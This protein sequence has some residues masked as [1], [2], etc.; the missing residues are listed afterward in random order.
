MLG[1]GLLRDGTSTEKESRQRCSVD[2]EAGAAFLCKNR[3]GHDWAGY[4]YVP[5]NSSKATEWALHV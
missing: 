3:G 1:S 2:R 4:M 5:Q